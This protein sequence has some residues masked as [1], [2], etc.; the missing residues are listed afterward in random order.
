[1][2]EIQIV[3]ECVFV[4]IEFTWET[5]VMPSIYAPLLRQLTEAGAQCAPYNA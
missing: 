3:V 4:S 1:M 5:E 2:V